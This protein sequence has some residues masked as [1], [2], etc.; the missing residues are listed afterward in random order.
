MTYFKEI[1]CYVILNT[2]DYETKLN[3]ICH[4]NKLIPKHINIYIY[5]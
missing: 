2:K 4:K 5:I 3:E 1:F